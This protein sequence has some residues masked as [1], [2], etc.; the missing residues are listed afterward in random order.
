MKLKKS[1]KITF[2]VLAAL[3]VLIVVL[4]ALVIS[5]PQSFPYTVEQAEADSL[6]ASEI[7]DMISDAVVDDEGNIPE[8]AVITIP[9]EN[10]NALLRI[11]AY[12]LNREL[13]D[14][15]IECAFGWE[16]SAVKAAACI[17]LPLSLAVVVRGTASPVIA[18]GKMNAPAK[19][20]KAGALPL[21]GIN[22]VKNVTADDIQDEKLKLAFEAI[23]DLAATPDGSLKIG[24]YPAKISNLT[25]ILMTEE[26]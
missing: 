19:N 4:A 8:I 26:D 13:K 6:L 24:I 16:N 18:N 9:P 5:K 12:R 10:V 7:V 1:L 2:T 22:V 20:L 23:H 25:R 15:G 21:P 14:D 11:A 17:P 3:I